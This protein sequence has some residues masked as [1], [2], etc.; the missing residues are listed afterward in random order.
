MFCHRNF[1]AFFL[2][3]S[4]VFTPILL[5]VEDST[6]SAQ[7]EPQ[8]HSSG[9]QAL[10]IEK[11]PQR[12]FAP[13]WTTEATYSTMLYIRNVHVA[14]AVIAKVSLILD[15]HTIIL[16]G[17]LVDSLQT[18]ALDLKKALQESGEAAEQSGG[19]VIE[20]EAES[21]GA[22]NAYAHVLDITRSLS[23]S[24]PFIEDGSPASVPLD[25]V[26][27]YYSKDT[28]ALV[29]LQNTTDVEISASMTIFVSGRPI[30][31]GKN[32][33]KPHEVVILKVASPAE[34][35]NE[36]GPRSAGVRVECDGNPGAVVAQGWVVDESIG[37][38]A[39]FAFHPRSNCGCS[40]DTQHKY[41][42]SIMIGKG[43][44]SLPP[45]G[46]SPYLV[47]SN[48]SEK[49]LTISPVF[50]YALNEERRTDNHKLSRG[51]LHSG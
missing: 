47:M 2:F 35:Q 43:G 10:E 38:S 26:A 25:A 1:V 36:N 30:D 27:W 14:Q 50:S 40:I 8:E 4:L 17:I 29:A 13:H 22:I 9:H 16:P 6:V 28:D 37:F 44:M 20:F 24:F 32:H 11:K 34:L 39:P 51:H 45:P 19:G 3:V 42:A 48:S 23:F 21:A 7:N 5:P 46:F 41:G 12:V 15:H 18:V 31:L 49:P 33:L